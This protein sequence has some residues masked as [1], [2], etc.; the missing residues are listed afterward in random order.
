MPPKRNKKRAASNGPT[1]DDSGAPAPKQTTRQHE[2][3]TNGHASA[4]ASGTRAQQVPCVPRGMYV[5]MR[6]LVSHPTQLRSTS[7]QEVSADSTLTQLEC[8]KEMIETLQLFD[9]Q[10]RHG[11]RTN[12]GPHS[13]DRP[14][15]KLPAGAENTIN[16]LFAGE[17]IVGRHW[18]CDI[19]KHTDTKTSHGCAIYWLVDESRNE[20]R[21][22]GATLLSAQ[23]GMGVA[24]HIGLDIASVANRFPGR[25][26]DMSKA[27][28]PASLA[29]SSTMHLILEAATR[30]QSRGRRTLPA[31][32]FRSEEDGYYI[33]WTASCI[34]PSTFRRWALRCVMSLGPSIQ[35]P[36]WA[37]RSEFSHY[38][39]TPA[40]KWP[41]FWTSLDTT[42]LKT[43]SIPEAWIAAAKRAEAGF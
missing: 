32:T 17:A 31:P 15:V 25:V 14:A 35:E 5:T 19:E 3:K 24:P 42:L 6:T 2:M 23:C 12:I 4:P 21:W 26:Q 1:H 11:I 39:I 20:R 9:L 30:R 36:S 16:N 34:D 41:Q 27:R 29:S 40:S 37:L 33:A 10:K 28:V 8:Q 43:N 7:L 38:H 13:P 18:K 22:F